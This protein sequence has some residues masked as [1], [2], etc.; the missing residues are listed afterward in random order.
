MMKGGEGQKI[1]DWKNM[2]NYEVIDVKVNIKG[3]RK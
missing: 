2:D 3:G 1:T